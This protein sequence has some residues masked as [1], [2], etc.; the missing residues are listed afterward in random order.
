MRVSRNP[1]DGRR[2]LIRSVGRGLVHLAPTRPQ[3]IV[4][5]EP[6]ASRKPE[7]TES[8]LQTSDGADLQRGKDMEW[9]L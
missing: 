9:R 5:V 4:R 7:M 2:R 3:S 8:T 6:L 1:I